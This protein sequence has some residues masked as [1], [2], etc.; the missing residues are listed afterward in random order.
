MHEALKMPKPTGPTNPLLRKL[1]RKLRER[2]KKLDVMLWRE[3]SERLLRPRRSR[4]EVNLSHL[5]RHTR[6]G[7]TLVVPGKVLA[8][9]KLGHPITVAAFRFSGP[10]RRKIRAAG[11]KA[12]SIRE[13]LEQNPDGKNV[14]I[15]E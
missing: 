5:N 15:M 8:A 2:G 13:L 9:G 7:T 1:A 3:L 6:E 12:I 11:G 14:V 4:A 10:A